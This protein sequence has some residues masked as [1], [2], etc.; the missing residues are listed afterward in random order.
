MIYH[1]IELEKQLQ[2][3]NLYLLKESGASEFYSF[4]PIYNDKIA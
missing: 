1:V 2:Q 3:I 4:I